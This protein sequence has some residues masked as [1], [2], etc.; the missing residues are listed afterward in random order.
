M[1]FLTQR[2]FNLTPT[3]GT[4]N[5]ENDYYNGY[6]L[7]SITQDY[8]A[9][10]SIS[11]SKTNLKGKY[12]SIDCIQGGKTDNT[13]IWLYI[14]IDGTNI[15][16]I[17]NVKN[18]ILDTL[19]RGGGFYIPSDANTLSIRIKNVYSNKGDAILGALILTS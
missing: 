18:Q 16:N 7:Y 11:L 4:M 6:E 2:F 9:T 19:T 8:D 1:I 14:T 13:G 15:F 10:L 3:S 5:K 17:N 12:C